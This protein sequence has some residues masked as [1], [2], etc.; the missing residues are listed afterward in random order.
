MNGAR[1]LN[2]TRKKLMHLL[3]V[4]TDLHIL[5]II[6]YP[7]IV[8]HQCSRKIFKRCS[9][10]AIVSSQIYMFKRLYDQY[11]IPK[12]AKTE[13]GTMKCTIE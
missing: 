2:Y 1:L 4:Y 12:D 7:P 6:I 8:V 13:M 3:Q 9:G 5:A 10:V 11:M